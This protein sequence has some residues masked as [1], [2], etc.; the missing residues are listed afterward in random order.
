MLVPIATIEGHWLND[1]DLEYFKL[2]NGSLLLL[3]LSLLTLASS[4]KNTKKSVFSEKHST[5]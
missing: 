1:G 3:I 5:N 4:S 2:E